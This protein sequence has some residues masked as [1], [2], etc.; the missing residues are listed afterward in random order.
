MRVLI[1]GNRIFANDMLW[2]FLQAGCHAQIIAPATTEELEQ[3]LAYVHPDLFMTLGAPLE[4]NPHI[5]TYLGNNRPSSMKYIH[6][7]TDGISSK[8]YMSFSGEGIE[9]DVIYLSKPD[10]VFT[11][12]PEMLELIRSKNIPCEILHYAYNPLSHY[13]MKNTE[14]TKDLINLVGQAYLAFALQNR[15]HHRYQSVAALLKPLL[16]NNY[17]IHFYGDDG[18]RELLKIFWDLDVPPQYFHGYLPYERTCSVYNSSF[19]NVV[20]QNH[21]HTL[22]KRT[23]EILGCGGFILSYDNEAIRELFTPGK[24]LVVSSSPDETLTLVAYYKDHPDAYNAI[25]HEALLSA[26][27]HTYKHRVDFILDKIKTL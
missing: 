5:L 25:R 2:G 9:M 11:M 8:A 1:W 3:I 22:T 21:K 15:E 14:S 23:F 10:M 17:T 7:D 24:D 16:E 6:W 18:Y 4:L 20:T 19:I 12:C 26:Q 13:A 27:N